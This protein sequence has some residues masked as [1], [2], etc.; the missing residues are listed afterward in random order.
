MSQLIDLSRLPPPQVL[1]AISHEEILAARKAAV[2][3][4]CPPD[5]QEAVG[6]TLSLESE[7]AVRL[8]RENAYR[9]IVL[10]Q[11]INESAAAVMLPYAEKDD[12]DN[13]AANMNTERLLIHPADPDAVPPVPAVWEDDDSLRMRAQMAFEGLSVAGPRGAYIFHA[14]SADGRVADV[15]AISPEPCEVVVTVLAREGDGTASAE[16]LAKVAAAL[17]DEDVRPV[18]DRVAVQ[19]AQI[20]PF[21]VDALLF[22]P[23]GAE[24]EPIL[25]AAKKSFDA[26]MV[27]QHRLGRGVNRSTIFAALHV[28]GV[29][30]VVLNQPATDIELGPHQAGHC[31]DYTLGVRE[32]SE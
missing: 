16:L 21:I 20:V 11:R 9:E 26:S 31:T 5:Q 10:R 24:A 12:L 14:R 3:A 7:L 27:K 30:R 22:L 4:Y 19:G 29:D 2:V 6:R 13:L 1:E 18:G 15:S 32:A 17:N 23:A 28:E 8:L 25:A